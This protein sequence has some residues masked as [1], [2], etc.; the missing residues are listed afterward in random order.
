MTNINSMYRIA[1][2]YQYR[3]VDG[4]KWT[5][6]YD[7]MS[8]IKEKVVATVEAEKLKA[9][10]KKDSLKHEYVVLEKGEDYPTE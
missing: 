4:I 6:W 3:S 5:R 8:D 7:Y 2:R 1:C 9:D 10:C